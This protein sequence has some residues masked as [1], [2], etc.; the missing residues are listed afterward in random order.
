MMFNSNKKLPGKNFFLDMEGFLKNNSW[1]LNASVWIM[2]LIRKLTQRSLM[3]L[4]ALQSSLMQFLAITNPSIW[5]CDN[6]LYITLLIGETKY[7]IY[8]MKNSHKSWEI[9]YFLRLFNISR[10]TGLLIS[11]SKEQ[12]I[13]I[14]ELRGLSSCV[15]STK[16]KEPEIF[17]WHLI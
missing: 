7:I 14:I 8:K 11:F 2:S 17:L 16:N 9:W 1:F 13:L 15:S 12:Y 3:K 6:S 10:L 4:W 5:L